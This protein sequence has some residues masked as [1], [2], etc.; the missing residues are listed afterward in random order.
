MMA[1]KVSYLAV[2]RQTK[3]REKV[4][5]TFSLLGISGQ[6]MAMVSDVRVST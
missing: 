1:G 5:F 6:M 3:E 4:R 2:A